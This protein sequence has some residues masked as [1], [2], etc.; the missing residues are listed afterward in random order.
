MGFSG[1]VSTGSMLDV[2][3]GDLIDYFGDD[4]RTKS[5]IVYMESIGDA[6]SFL[7]AAREISLSKP[8]LVIKPGGP[9]QRRK[10]RLRIPVLD[11]SDE[12]LD[13]AFRRSG[14]FRVTAFPTSSICRRCWHASRC[15]KVRGL[16]GD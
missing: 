4:P 12:V 9:Q 3:W 7:S 10:Q 6:Q 2:G 5:I 1:F 14:V 11:R 13:A 16:H 8:I 15:H